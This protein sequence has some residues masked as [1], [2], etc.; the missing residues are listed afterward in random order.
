[1]NQIYMV[2]AWRGSDEGYRTL[3]WNLSE[4]QALARIA[5]C[6]RLW[7][8]KAAPRAYAETAGETDQLQLI[9][10]LQ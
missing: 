7:P 6:Q 8:D 5:L 10:K 2:A 1:M 4:A 9:R 3:G